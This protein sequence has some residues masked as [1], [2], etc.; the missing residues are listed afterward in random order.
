LKRRWADALQTGTVWA[1]AR[2]LGPSAG[3]CGPP[4]GLRLLR[5]STSRLLWLADPAS[6]EG[7]EGCTVG[8]SH[9]FGEH[10]SHP[11]LS[12]DAPP[13]PAVIRA[14]AVNPTLRD[15]SR[16]Y[17]NGVLFNYSNDTMH[18]VSAVEIGVG[19]VSSRRCGGGGGGGGGGAAPPTAQWPRICR[20]SRSPRL[21]RRSQPPGLAGSAPA[22][23]SP[24]RRCSTA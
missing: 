15:I 12:P 6:R 16:L 22:P 5:C 10:E 24:Q 13:A 23:V 7:A 11:P 4:S 19:R 9:V 17:K 20:P 21:P 3:S 2:L 1:V 8:S 14:P 18:E